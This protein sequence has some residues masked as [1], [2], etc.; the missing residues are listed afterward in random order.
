MSCKDATSFKASIASG[1]AMESS[2]APRALFIVLPQQLSG[3]FDMALSGER[4]PKDPQPQLM[5]ARW[6]LASPPPA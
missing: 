2:R 5:H 4:M 6:C 1:T 3:G